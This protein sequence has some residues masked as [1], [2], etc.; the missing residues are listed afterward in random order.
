[1]AAQKTS[2]CSHLLYS[3][4]QCPFITEINIFSEIISLYGLIK[5]HINDLDPFKVRYI[6]VLMSRNIA[7]FMCS[8]TIAISAETNVSQKPRNY[9]SENNYSLHVFNISTYSCAD[10][11]VFAKGGGG[12][13]GS[14]PDCQRTALIT[15]C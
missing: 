1:M 5:R 13:E 3:K 14:R 6:N 9:R 15:L 4:Q 7:L 2:F 12:G 11:G 8:L 10:P